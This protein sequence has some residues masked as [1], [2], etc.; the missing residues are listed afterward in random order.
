MAKQVVNIGADNFIIRSRI[1]TVLTNPTSLPMQRL[2]K[3]AQSEGRL[4][5][6]KKG[7]KERSLIITDSNHVILSSVSP[8]T[9]KKRLEAIA[10]GEE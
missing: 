8:D 3:E 10:E 9:L 7:K 4:I 6:A 5:D 2:R 1:V